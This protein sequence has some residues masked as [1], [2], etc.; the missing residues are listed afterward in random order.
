MNQTE[1]DRPTETGASEAPPP[2]ANDTVAPEVTPE[3]APEVALDAARAEAAELMDKLLRAMA[4]L[5]NQRRRH[6]R[7]R[8][9]TAKYAAGRFAREILSVADNLRRALDAAPKSEE[10]GDSL[11]NLI[12]GVEVTER[13]LLSAFERHDIRRID[14]LGEKFDPNFH[15]AVFELPDPSQKPGTVVQVVAPGYTIAGRLLRPAMVGIAKA[16]N[17]GQGNG[18]G[19][20]PAAPGQTIDTRA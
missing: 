4:E 8:E 5:E 13:E 20:S 12:A 11:K 19:A 1:P 16:P 10:L 14:A 3:V 9:D 2:P 18:P 17:T 15:Q 7:E 6:E